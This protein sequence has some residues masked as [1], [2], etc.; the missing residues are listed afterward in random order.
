MLSDEW[1]IIL[2]SAMK[3]YFKS[4]MKRFP[5]KPIKDAINATRNYVEGYVKKM[6]ETE[7][8]HETHLWIESTLNEILME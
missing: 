4:Y 7:I 1:K 3:K 6:F 2:K 5:G 8:D